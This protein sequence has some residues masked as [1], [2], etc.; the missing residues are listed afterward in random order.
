MTYAV[1]CFHRTKGIQ[2]KRKWGI[3]MTKR[4]KRLVTFLTILL[5]I[6]I[7]PVCYEIVNWTLSM[8]SYQAIKNSGTPVTATIYSVGTNEIGGYAY[9]YYPQYTFSVSEDIMYYAE[10]AQISSFLP[11]TYT[12][13]DTAEIYYTPENPSVVATNGAQPSF[14]TFTELCLGAM[15]LVLTVSLSSLLK[16]TSKARTVNVKPKKEKKSVRK[17]G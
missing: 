17:A 5:A 16:N 7:L 15:I 13:G 10:D 8:S 1:S 3:E 14:F 12:V 9:A 6:T 4:R 2:D 11:D